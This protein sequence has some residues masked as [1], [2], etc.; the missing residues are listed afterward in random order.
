MSIVRRFFEVCYNTTTQ[1]GP[2]DFDYLFFALL[3]SD[4]ALVEGA[5]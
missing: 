2:H 1:K 5:P 4:R 3:I